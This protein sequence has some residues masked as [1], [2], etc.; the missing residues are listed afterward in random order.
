MKKNI[1]YTDGFTE[2]IYD[3]RPANK[4]KKRREQSRAAGFF[5]YVFFIVAL[6]GMVYQIYRVSLINSRND[7]IARI[8]SEIENTE[9]E[10][11]NYSERYTFLYRNLIDQAKDA[12]ENELGMV[13]AEGS[14][15]RTI[16]FAGSSVVI[17]DAGK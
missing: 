13:K 14:D 6:I 4:T 5:K 1:E 9:R 3:E 7:A 15:M 11:N 16:C 8:Q 10:Y 12:A 17:A 2:F